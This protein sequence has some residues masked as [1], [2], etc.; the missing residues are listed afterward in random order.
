MYSWL[1]FQRKR[2]NHGTFWA[3]RS[4]TLWNDESIKIET[5]PYLS[6]SLWP[7]S[8]NLPSTSKSGSS[9]WYLCKCSLHVRWLSGRVSINNLCQV[10]DM[11]ISFVAQLH[12][13]RH[14]LYISLFAHHSEHWIGLQCCSVTVSDCSSGECLQTISTISS[15]DTLLCVI[16]V[17]PDPA[18][19][20]NVA[21]PQMIIRST[22]IRPQYALAAI[23]MTISAYL[24][25]RFHVRGPILIANSLIALVGLPIMGF[26]SS[27]GARYFG[28]FLVTAG[29][30][31]NI[32]TAL[33]YQANNVRGQWK[34]ALT[35]AL[36]VAF[37]GIGGISGGTIF[38]PQDKPRYIPGISAAIAWVLKAFH[39]HLRKSPPK[40]A[41]HTN[42]PD[43]PR[44]NCLVII[45]VL[46]LSGYYHRANR[47]ADKGEKILEGSEE[48]RY[49]IWLIYFR[50]RH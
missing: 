2:I 25:D 6:A 27:N 17:A 18:V 49:T 32:P 45:S 11:W 15:N 13:N 29:T 10:A 19:P 48:F 39:K 33:A 21:Q 28:V 12:H 22:N 46:G 30:N 3:R 1:I 41:K 47:Q 26:A 20:P 24:G 16:I 44:C 7:A 37:G 42:Y 50:A 4:E 38:R 43:P 8:W 5:M 34:R 36:F 14:D 23:L 31:A 40:K 35:S 9:H